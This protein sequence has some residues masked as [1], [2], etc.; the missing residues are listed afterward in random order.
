MLRTSMLALLVV[1]C[2][3]S[4]TRAQNPDAGFTPGPHNNPETCGDLWRGIGLPDYAREQERDTVVVCH[5]RYVLSHNNDDK[6]PDW[7]FEHLTPE[8]ISGTNTRPKIKFKPDPFVAPDK[9]AVDDDYKNSKFDRGHQAPSGDFTAN[10]EW[11]V[12]SFFLSNI[13]PQVG[14]GFNQGIWKKLEDHVRDLVSERGD[15]YVM[16]GPVNPNE[17]GDAQVVINDTGNACRK[18]IVLKPLPRKSICGAKMSGCVNGVTVPVALYKVVYDPRMQ[19]A[20]AFIMPNIDHRDANG[21]SNS[22]EYIKKFQ[23]TVQIVEKFTGL[24]FFPELPATTRRTVVSQCAEP[25]AH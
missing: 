1:L 5:S 4:T 20:N 22:F 7:V 12:E 2:L 24:E 3:A 18:T 16:T 25:M 6:T 21:F 19:R 13:V 10:R 17:V 8:Q 15:L 23:V 11:M 14:V 9:R